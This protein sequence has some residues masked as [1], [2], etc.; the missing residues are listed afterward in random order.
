MLASLCFINSNFQNFIGPIYSHF[1]WLRIRRIE[2]F[3]NEINCVSS[4]RKPLAKW[5]DY[6]GKDKYA[7]VNGIF[8][9]QILAQILLEKFDTFRVS[10]RM[11][12]IKE[13]RVRKAIGF[14]AMLV[15]LVGYSSCPQNHRRIPFEKL[16]S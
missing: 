7:D 2:L 16:N 12:T 4:L 13:G 3:K 10:G 1:I 9:F 8:D 14:F 5:V 15:A 6:M 11:T